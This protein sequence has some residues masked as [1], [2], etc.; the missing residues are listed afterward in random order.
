MVTKETRPRE[1]RRGETYEVGERV[2]D[3]T[4]NK[5]LL[6]FLMKPREYTVLIGMDVDPA[7]EPESIRRLVYNCGA[8][9]S[10]QEEPAFLISSKFEKGTRHY[11]PFL[12][13]I[14][15]HGGNQ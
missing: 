6:V 15:Q 13:F 5:P 12:D 4:T 1:L 3:P 9:E 11:G 2:V 8:D 14:Q 10:G 7:D